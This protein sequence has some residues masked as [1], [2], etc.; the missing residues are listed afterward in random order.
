M[1]TIEV[2]DHSPDGQSE[3]GGTAAP[4]RKLIGEEDDSGDNDNGGKGVIDEDNDGVNCAEAEACY[5]H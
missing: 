4:E 2:L 5:S 3:N 1:V